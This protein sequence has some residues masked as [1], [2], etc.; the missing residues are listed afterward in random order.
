MYLKFGELGTT[1][2]WTPKNRKGPSILG[3]GVPMH[4]PL[5]FKSRGNSAGLSWYNHLQILALK[6]MRA[7]S[8]CIKQHPGIISSVYHWP[9]N[10]Q[11]LPL[12]CNLYELKWY[13]LPHPRATNIWQS[14]QMPLGSHGCPP[15]GS[16]WLMHNLRR[17]GSFGTF[18][19]YSDEV[20]INLQVYGKKQPC[21]PR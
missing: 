20:S 15:G 8:E 3:G 9:A 6:A 13:F 1:Q 21:Q 16:H 10:P 18:S 5:I 11:G 2:D 14:W 19:C 17:P 12:G 7:Q 4:G